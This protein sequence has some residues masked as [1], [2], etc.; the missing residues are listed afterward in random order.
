VFVFNAQ[1]YRKE[2]F[3]TSIADLEAAVNRLAPGV[4]FFKDVEA[5]EYRETVARWKATL[6]AVD[7]AQGDTPQGEELPGSI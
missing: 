5:Q 3:R 1:N 6:M 7:T 4:A 2:F